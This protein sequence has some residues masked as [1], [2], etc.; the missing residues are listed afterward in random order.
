MS[1]AAHLAWKVTLGGASLAA[2]A[3]SAPAPRR[4]KRGLRE[5]IVRTAEA[6]GLPFDRARFE[7]VVE[8]T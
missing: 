3:P 4:E 5:R 6:P 2:C 8:P 7:L 1:R